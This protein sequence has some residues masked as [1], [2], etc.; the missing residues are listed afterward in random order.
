M[1]REVGAEP[2]EKNL[3]LIKM[4]EYIPRNTKDVPKE[5]A[6]VTQRS[7]GA[8]DA[9]ELRVA[10]KGQWLRSQRKQKFKMS[11][12]APSKNKNITIRCSIN[13]VME[14]TP[15]KKSTQSGE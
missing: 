1:P 4:K 13:Q 9:P 14:H 15:I 5:S 11:D 7:R 2:S 10:H 12:H 6:W 8:T 3:K